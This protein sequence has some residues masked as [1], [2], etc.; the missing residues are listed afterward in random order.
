VNHFF[1]RQKLADQDLA[2]MDGFDGDDFAQTPSEEVSSGFDDP[3]AD[4]LARE[5]EELGDL[6]QELGLSNGAV[7][8]EADY[9]AEA[10]FAQVANLLITVRGRVARW[11]IFKPKLPIWVHFGGPWNGKCCY[12]LRQFGTISDP[13]V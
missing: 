4:F 11:F 2:E 13:L 6:G 12:I 1:P 3:A 10:N 5:Q 8:G 9:L 7:S